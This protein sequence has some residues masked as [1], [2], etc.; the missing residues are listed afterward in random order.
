MDTGSAGIVVDA[1]QVAER[2]RWAVSRVSTRVRSAQT[3]EPDLTRLAV[4]ILAN[5][6]ASG[7]H[8]AS[9]LAI[10][11]GLQRQSLTR[12]LN[13]LDAA[14]RIRRERSRTDGREQNIV[15]L[16]AGRKALGEHVRSGNAWLAEGVSRLTEA[17]R[18]VLAIAADLMVRIAESAPGT[19]SED[20]AAPPL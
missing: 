15:I 6:K 18:G 20:G 4:S 9:Q 19:V 11:E 12:T 17:E 14:G 13:D 1:S 10:M 3:G 7:P 2:L 16:E 8:T 5:L